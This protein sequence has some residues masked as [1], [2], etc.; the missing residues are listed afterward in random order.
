[1]R[2]VG[3]QFRQR[4]AKMV[5]T[6]LGVCVNYLEEMARPRLSLAMWL[7]QGQRVAPP[8]SGAQARLTFDPHRRD[9]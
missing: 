7:F 1:M 3:W 9:Q 5:P 4:E 6:G 8:Y 2:Q